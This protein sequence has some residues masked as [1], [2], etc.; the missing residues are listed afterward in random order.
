MKNTEA[1]EYFYGKMESGA[2]TSDRQQEAYETAVEALEKQVSKEMPT[3]LNDCANFKKDDFYFHL[4]DSSKFVPEDMEMVERIVGCGLRNFNNKKDELVTFLA[5]VLCVNKIDVS[6]YC[7]DKILTEKTIREKRQ[8]LNNF[9]VTFGSAE[10]YPYGRDAYIIVRAF[11]EREA[12]RKYRKR[13]PDI[14]EGILNCAFLYNEK[15]FQSDVCSFY[16]DTVPS[17]III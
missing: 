17:E 10:Y 4:L 14:H 15:T 16:K 9:Y 5:D 13:H 11:T 7:S 2:I 1:I 3:V 6:A 12:A 8:G